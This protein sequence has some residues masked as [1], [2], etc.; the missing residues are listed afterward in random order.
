MN[1]DRITYI[2]CN[3]IFKPYANPA[4]FHNHPF[5]ALNF[6]SKKN[7]N[8]FYDVNGK[9]MDRILLFI[10]ISA[11]VPTVAHA[12]STEPIFAVTQQC[13]Q[14]NSSFISCPDNAYIPI[15]FSISANYAPYYGNFTVYVTDNS[16]Y[17]EPLSIYN[18]PCILSG[19][20]T[21]TCH[22][23]AM[24]IPISYGNGTAERSISLSLISSNYPQAVFR[25]YVNVTIRHYLTPQEGMILS[26][27]N[28]TYAEYSKINTTYSFFC[29]AYMICNQSLEENITKA[30]T[31]LAAASGSIRGDGNLTAIYSSI[32]RAN[33]TLNANMQAYLSFINSSSST[34]NTNLDAIHTLLLA[35]R[36]FDSNV[37][38][39]SNCSVG[40]TTYAERISKEI[41]VLEQYSMQ[42]SE[43]QAHAYANKTLA[44]E[45]EV[46]SSIASCRQAHMAAAQ[47]GISIPQKPLLYVSLAVVAVLVV[48]AL[49]RIRE[50]REVSSI[51]SMGGEPETRE[52]GEKGSIEESFDRWLEETLAKKNAKEKKEGSG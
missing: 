20:T 13:V 46:N 10:L 33:E 52:G 22:I 38:L 11:L 44:L 35:T 24:P 51:R 25:Q 36:E 37:A 18:T 9:K 40:N 42:N 3:K 5:G 8:E 50:S 29:N 48:Y 31:Y 23:T 26:A 34:V 6:V 27:Y 19:T 15:S 45:Q 14:L 30:G 28:K 43:M 47:A 41:S 49:F 1:H 16:N 2:R 21:V 17:T 4:Y 12:F 7:I 39:L 32:E